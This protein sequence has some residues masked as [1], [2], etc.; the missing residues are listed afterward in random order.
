MTDRIPEKYRK[1]IAYGILPAILVLYAFTGTR[2]GV[3]VVDATFTL[4]GFAY[5]E[6]LNAF[7]RLAYYLPN[8][9]GSLFTHLPGGNTLSGMNAYGSA[10]IALTALVAY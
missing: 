6:K 10:I 4:T 7:W 1:V 2:E 8:A 5:P 9:L 3:D